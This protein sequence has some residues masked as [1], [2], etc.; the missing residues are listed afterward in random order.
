[1]LPRWRLWFNLSPVTSIG[2]LRI[3][4]KRRS[5]LFALP[6]TL[7]FALG[8]FPAGAQSTPSAASQAAP[9]AAPADLP[10][11]PGIGAGASKPEPVPTGPTIVMDTSM[12]RLTCKTFDKQAPNAVA[13]F[14]GL[15]EGTKDWTVNATHAR[16]HGK[17]FYDG[18]TF[19]RVIPGFMIQ[20]GTQWAMARAIPVITLQTR[21]R[22]S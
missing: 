10:N 3:G 14:I 20:G 1:M 22:R 7:L 12:G 2:T 18:L 9:A 5:V 17:R 8:G 6:L 15:A 4:I 11:A 19:H 21:L 13:N 16:Q